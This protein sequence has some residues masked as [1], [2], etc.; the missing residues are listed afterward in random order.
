MNY[1]VFNAASKITGPPP[2]SRPSFSSARKADSACATWRGRV[3]VED[4]GAA[5]GG[6][7]LHP[8]AAGDA[9]RAP[10]ADV[11]QPR[12]GPPGACK[13]GLRGLHGHL[14][15]ASRR[16]QGGWSAPGSGP[17]SHPPWTTR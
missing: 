1:G 2:P 10:Q 8:E 7:G 9:E 13:R 5:V 17:A 15:Q 14:R 16:R 11:H 3:D 6:R 4:A 12:A